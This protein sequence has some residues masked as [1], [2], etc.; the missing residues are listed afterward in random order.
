MSVAVN[1]A[2]RDLIDISFPDE[3]A[4]LLQAH[5][6]PPEMLSLEITERSVMADPTRTKEILDRLSE[7]EEGREGLVGIGVGG[8]DRPGSQR[9][10]EEPR[11]SSDGW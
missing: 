9:P 11:Q 2:M 10:R 5:R 8:Q 3:V 4:E 7:R 1:L 6:M